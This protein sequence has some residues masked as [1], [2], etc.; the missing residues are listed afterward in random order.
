[1][2]TF[3]KTSTR[4]TCWLFPNDA[5]GHRAA[6]PQRHPHRRSGRI[7][8]LPRRCSPG[9]RISDADSARALGSSRL[10]PI[11]ARVAT[12]GRGVARDLGVGAIYRPRLVLSR[13][14]LE[15]P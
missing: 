8:P 12:A 6:R 15:I 10:A 9:S 5:P 3:A 4:T 11:A 7:L 2:D 13:L 1:M 14:S